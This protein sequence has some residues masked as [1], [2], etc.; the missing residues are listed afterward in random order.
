MEDNNNNTPA[1]PWSP[2][3]P[4]PYGT[5][6]ESYIS[7]EDIPTKYRPYFNLNE[8]PLDRVDYI[9][10]IL[11]LDITEVRD[12]KTAPASIRNSELRKLIVPKYYSLS[13]YPED[14]MSPYL[15]FKVMKKY[16]KNF[17]SPLYLPYRCYLKS[18]AKGDPYLRSF[19]IDNYFPY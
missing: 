11:M 6:G 9:K 12:L 1:R 7:R 17:T 5:M 2:D 15:G 3:G 18:E 19:L 4:R 10:K 13:E 14:T 16:D 8:G